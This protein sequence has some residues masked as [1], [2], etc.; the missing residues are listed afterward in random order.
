VSVLLCDDDLLPAPAALDAE[1]TGERDLEEALLD[2]DALR[3]LLEVLR[4]GDLLDVLGCCLA[5][6]DLLTMS[7]AE[8]LFEGNLLVVLGCFA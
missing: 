3:V 7:D 1:H 2:D 5:G 6:D 8:V 4:D